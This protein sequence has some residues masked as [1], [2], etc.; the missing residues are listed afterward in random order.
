MHLKYAYNLN[1]VERYIIWSPDTDLA[2]LGIHSA[3]KF[4]LKDVYLRTGIKH[5]KHFIPIHR[6]VNQL[7]TTMCQFLPAVYALTGCDSNSSFRAHSKKSAFKVLQEA[8]DL[9]E[10]S[11]IVLNS[12]HMSNSAFVSCKRFV[13]RVHDS[14]TSLEDLNVLR[15]RMF[16]KSHTSNGKLRPT[17]DSLKEHIMCANH[18]S[19]IWYN[20]DKPILNLPSPNENGWTLNEEELIPLMM[21]KP[22]APAALLELTECGCKGNCGRNMQ[23]QKSQLMLYRFLQM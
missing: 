13:C 6:I 15:Y 11:N 8:N 19:Y 2:V 18:Q 23:M 9:C 4:G 7:S 1:T 16:T 20:A 5:K 22:P 21:T 12:S 17:E 3:E 14:K 10:E